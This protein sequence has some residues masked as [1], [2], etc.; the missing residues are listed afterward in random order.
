M[1]KQHQKSRPDPREERDRHL[2][3]IELYERR[4]REAAASPST[5]VIADL[6]ALVQAGV[7]RVVR[8]FRRGAAAPKRAAAPAA[9]KP[10]HPKPKPRAK[11]KR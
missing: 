3:R 7:T 2:H 9:V 5:G 4:Q 11:R 10:R 6:R 1:A 8:L